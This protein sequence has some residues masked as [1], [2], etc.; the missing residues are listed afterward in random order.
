MAASLPFFGSKGDAGPSTSTAAAPSAAGG[1]ETLLLFVRLSDP[2]KPPRSV[3]CPGSTTVRSFWEGWVAPL[4]RGRAVPPT[5]LRFLVAGRTIEPDC[6]A[7]LVDVG[8]SHLSTIEVAGRLPSQG[9][10]RLHQL[11]ENLV[12]TLAPVA[13]ATAGSGGGG[14][15]KDPP[16][17]DEPSHSLA[18]REPIMHAIDTEIGDHRAAARCCGGGTSASPCH[19]MACTLRPNSALRLC[20][21]LLHSNDVLLADE[22]HRW[23]YDAV[24]D[25]LTPEGVAVAALLTLRL[26]PLLWQHPTKK[27]TLLEMAARAPSPDLLLCLMPALHLSR[28]KAL[29]G[30]AALSARL[31]ADGR[32]VFPR[33]LASSGALQ[34]VSMASYKALHAMALHG[35]HEL[36][37]LLLGSGA[38]SAQHV[39]LLLETALQKKGKQP[40][41]ERVAAEMVAAGH[42]SA[43]VVAMLLD[44]SLHDTEGALDLEAVGLALAEACDFNNDEAMELLLLRW[45]G[46]CAASQAQPLVRA[47]SARGDAERVERLLATGKGGTAM[48]RMDSA[49]RSA[50]ARA[51]L[52]HAA[53]SAEQRTRVLRTLLAAGA[54]AK[55][56]HGEAALRNAAR[57]G[58]AEAME[59]LLGMGT[60]V[61]A[62]DEDGKTVLCVA[63]QSGGCASVHTL[64]EHGAQVR[65]RCPD[66]RE[67]LDFAVDESV[68]ALL[69]AEVEKLRMGLLDEL[70]AEE[71]LAA[72][73]AKGGG[74]SKSKKAK[75]AEKAEQKANGEAGAVHSGGGGC[76]LLDVAVSVLG[77]GNGASPKAMRLSSLISALY[78]R[79]A[80]FKEE[81]RNAGGAKSW[82]TLHSDAFI[83]DTDGPAGQESVKL[84][85]RPKDAAAPGGNQPVE[86]A[87]SASGRFG[88]IGSGARGAPGGDDEALLAEVAEADPLG[89]EKKIRAIQ[90]KLRRVQ[91][92]EERAAR[93]LPVDGDQLMLLGS[94][95]KL[96]RSLRLLL[97]QWAVLEPRLIEQQAQRMAALANSECAV[98]LEEY[99]SAFS[100]IRTSCCGYHFHKTCLQQCIESKGHCPICFADK[101][102]CRVVEQRVRSGHTQ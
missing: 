1:S 64:L 54:D 7:R 11:L 31:L 51:G 21:T 48:V 25:A 79:S 97:D 70:L 47:F 77:G 96:Q 58:H 52:A 50:L 81:I 71:E 26:H 80:S 63:A 76:S 78:E 86:R 89:I 59:L 41:T 5:G 43:A 3:Y 29:A 17:D 92:I 13:S 99:S 44:L 27:Q 19:C 83:L 34:A 60:N 10:S 46:R 9:F 56:E 23:L 88:A 75:K 15:G 2:L 6:C 94:K 95:P 72:A 32:L 38:I 65:M 98:C 8:V 37:S 91:E 22:G 4:L 66:G 39:S 82:L 101:T 102:Q 85:T 42:S 62:V 93:S 69:L 40:L 84:R 30:G 12:E 90:K 20:G 87:Q 74:K 16:A 57:D 55:S 73:S 45:K 49:Q 53:G 67:P 28:H 68:R 33:R 100:A 35:R 61:N 24:V 18:S 36:L 14:G